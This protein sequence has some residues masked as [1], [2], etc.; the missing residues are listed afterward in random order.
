[1]WIGM[2]HMYHN[3]PW[4]IVFVR[5]GVNLILSEFARSTVGATYRGGR[6]WP[7]LAAI[8]IRLDA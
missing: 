6:A 3:R 1:M 5:S 2:V 7:L 8:Y 4:L